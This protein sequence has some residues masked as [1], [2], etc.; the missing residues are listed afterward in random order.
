MSVCIVCSAGGHLSEALAACSLV[1]A[2]RYYI[3]YDEPH[4]R[5]RLKDEEV[6]YVVDPHVSPVLYVKNVIQS[7]VVFIRKRPK[8]VISNGAGIALAT[9]VL[10]KLT[11]ARLIFIE[12]GA[13]VTTPSR[14]G[15]LVYRFADLFIVQ[16][17]PLLRHYPDAVYGGP[18]L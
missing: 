6:Y 5:E 1:T 7:L 2:E 10:A 17:K 14:T 18:L 11:G 8:V 15:R 13:R 4:V 12:S 3:T 16:W 9:C